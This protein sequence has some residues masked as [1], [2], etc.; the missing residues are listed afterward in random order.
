MF[1]ATFLEED[2]LTTYRRAGREP[3]SGKVLCESITP[4][5]AQSSGGSG[6]TDVG[7]VSWVVPTVQMRGATSAIGTPLHSWQMTG[8][9]KTDYAKKGMVHAA[10]AMAGTA[11]AALTDATL[12]EAAAGDLAER[13]ERTPYVS[14]LPSGA[15]PALDMSR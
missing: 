2:I 3:E 7:D 13:T 15:E 12:R 6:S 11:L 10:K 5:E 4:A 1:Q 8:Q 9:G 14:P